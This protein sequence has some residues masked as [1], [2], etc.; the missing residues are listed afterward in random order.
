MDLF[1]VFVPVVTLLWVS[2]VGDP[3]TR[4]FGENEKR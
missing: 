1:W 4:R 3:L 2:T